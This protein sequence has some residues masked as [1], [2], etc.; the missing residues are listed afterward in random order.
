MR[1]QGIEFGCMS[2]G[3]K[4]GEGNHE[5]AKEL[6]EGTADRE[7]RWTHHTLSL[8]ER[9][10]KLERGQR[11]ITFDVH[12]DHAVDFAF[13]WNAEILGRPPVMGRF[14]DILRNAD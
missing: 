10:K 4:Y 1:Q 14:M 5:R 13:R 11:L 2:L 12:E 6:M 8:A 7:W 9:E 3:L